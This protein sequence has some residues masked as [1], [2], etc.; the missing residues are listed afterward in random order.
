MVTRI[1]E[2]MRD[3]DG[4]LVLVV[5]VTVASTALGMDSDELPEGWVGPLESFLEF[6]IAETTVLLHSMSALSEDDLLRARIRRELARRRQPMPAF[7]ADLPRARIAEAWHMDDGFG[8][9]IALGV[10]WPGGEVASMLIYID[11]AMGTVVKDAFLLDQPLAYVLQRYLDAGATA[12]GGQVGPEPVRL[13]VARA[14]VEDALE[15]YDRLTPTWTQDFWPACRPLVELLL[16]TMPEVED[17]HDREWQ[18]PMS[19]A[20]SLTR[21]FL[22]S[23]FALDLDSSGPV[24]RATTA[25]FDRSDA[26]SNDPLIWDPG[27]VKTVLT[28][29]LPFDPT[30]EEAD[31]DVVPEVLPKVILFAHHNLPVTPAVT[32]Q[33]LVAIDRHLPEFQE[34]RF[35]R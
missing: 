15:N 32:R 31:L 7:V 6:D 33:T 3:P 19:V 5:G 30:L 4:T 10:E 16:R 23:S 20:V 17:D 22:A 2:A 1:R 24:V 34:Q 8:T 27:V 25:I 13:D 21:D 11:H 29:V 18:P 14:R 12:L 26:S 35:R 28:E 9:G